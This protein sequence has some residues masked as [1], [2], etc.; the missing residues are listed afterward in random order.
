M[1]RHRLRRFCAP[2]SAS[3]ALGLALLFL[4][5]TL[6]S[7]PGPSTSWTPA[8]PVREVTPLALTPTPLAA[9]P[10]ND[11]W[12]MYMQNTGH[13]S[14]NLNETTLSVA[15]VHNISL[16][17]TAHVRGAIQGSAVVVNGAVYQGTG[18]GN[19][20][21]LYANNG[22]TRWSTFIGTSVICNTTGGVADTATVRDGNVY[23]A[24]GDSYFYALNASTGAIEWR[25]FTG[26]T[27]QGFYGWGSPLY[28]DGYLYLGLASRCDSPLVPAALLKIDPVAHQVVAAFN[29]TQ[30]GGLG[31]SIWSTPTI[32]FTRNTI[33]VTTGN[34]ATRAQAPP[35]FD[36]DSVIA[37][38]ATTL[39]E[40]GIW[41]IPFAQR[42]YDGD[43]GATPSLVSG[44][45]HDLVVAINKNG[46]LYAWNQSNVSSGAL[47][48]DQLG[49]GTANSYNIATASV[50]NGLIYQ[51]AGQANISGNISLGSF[52]AIYPS[53]GTIKWEKA[54]IDHVFRAAAYA[55]GFLVVE[56]T[57]E[58]YILSAANGRSLY[59]ST[60]AFGMQSDPTVAEGKIF[61]GCNG[62]LNAYGVGLT[63]GA[64]A[65]PTTGTVPL[66]VAFSTTA[67]GGT[68]P[69]SY[70]W[71][72]GDGTG[73]QVASTSHTYRTTGTFHAMIWVNDSE[74]N[75]SNNQFA[76]TVNAA[77]SNGSGT[78][79]HGKGFL[80]SYGLILGVL[81]AVVVMLLIL[82][83]VYRRRRRQGLAPPPPWTPPSKP[84]SPPPPSGPPPPSAAARSPT[85]A[86]RG[87]PP[88]PSKPP[89]SA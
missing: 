32:N 5:P 33:Y 36:Q 23:I 8:A 49:Q 15:N 75:S 58:L 76:I 24:G 28:A 27:S 79:S 6:P 47:W 43:F 45:G 55:N 7:Q 72:F 48:A 2:A 14:A 35:Q 85:P 68:P 73:A 21:S 31:A 40:E 10:L 66:Q 22:S 64:T 34:S 41:T 1:E 61:I 83:V 71:K 53:N 30:S 13:N 70:A 11:D 18:T 17:W 88:G 4:L 65:V 42:G 84:A 12:P 29:T 9:P 54:M 67:H 69:Y 16:L 57:K 46:V 81:G 82:A 37:V 87:P 25:V 52:Y 3:I 19:I 60:C 20:T 74:G 38:N 56:A 63:S 51:G 44:G 26:N 62:Y 59:K 86:P 78:P 77:G 39:A 50:A 89:G 80:A